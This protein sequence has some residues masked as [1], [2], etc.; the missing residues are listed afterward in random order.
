MNSIAD[1]DLAWVL[2]N[3]VVLLFSLSLHESAHAW[4]AERRGDY[5]GRYLGR[6]TLNPVAHIDPIGTILF[7]VLGLLSGWA[8]FGWAKPVPVNPSNLRH[9]RMDHLL[10]AAAGPASNLLALVGFLIGLK[11]LTAYFSAHIAMQ[12]SIVYPLFLLFQAG[13]LLNAILA[14]FNLIPV[15]PLDGSWILA[16]LLPSNLARVFDTI[17]PYSFILLVALLWSG[18]VDV[19]LRPILVLVRV[20]AS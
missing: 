5:T 8:M 14:V 15:P 18:L 1:I 16:G 13:V 11:V 3:I 10:I 6:V 19:V 2:I 17:R 4:V 20:L 12:H 9:P 7:P